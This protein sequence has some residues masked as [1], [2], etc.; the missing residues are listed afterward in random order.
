[1]QDFQSNCVFVCLCFQMDQSQVWVQRLRNG[2]RV[3]QAQSQRVIELNSSGWITRLTLDTS[4]PSLYTRFAHLCVS[5]HIHNKSFYFS[6]YYIHICIVCPHALYSTLLGR[7]ARKGSGACCWEECPGL[8]HESGTAGA[9]SERNGQ[10]AGQTLRDESLVQ[11]TVAVQGCGDGR[12]A[13]PYSPGNHLPLCI[14][15][16]S[17]EQQETSPEV[18]RDC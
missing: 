7:Q 8:G 14:M 12:E 18:Q 10:T 2:M 1:M 11:R 16:V 4:P 17:E 9:G 6:F 5:K 3:G 13:L 15:S